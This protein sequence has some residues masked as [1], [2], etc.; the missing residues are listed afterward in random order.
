VSLS[1]ARRYLGALLVLGMASCATSPPAAAPAVLIEG[2]PFYAQEAHQCGPAS[3]A[4][5]LNFWGAGVTPEEI[6]KDIYSPTAG[7]TLDMDLVLSS[8]WTWCSTPGSVATTPGS[9][10]GALTTS[11]PA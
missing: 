7:G 4:G 2:V 10:A 8:T 3:L 6:A 5:V 9:S 11:R 1:A